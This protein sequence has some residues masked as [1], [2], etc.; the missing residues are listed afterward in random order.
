MS[1]A[2]LQGAERQL[3]QLAAKRRST[4][5]QVDRNK[6][7]IHDGRLAKASMQEAVGTEQ[8]ATAELRRVVDGTRA[9]LAERTAAR[10]ELLRE[11][12]ECE[13]NLEAERESITTAKT[14]RKGLAAAQSALS[15]VHEELMALSSDAAKKAA[16]EAEGCELPTDLVPAPVTVSANAP[17]DPDTLWNKDFADPARDEIRQAYQ[18]ELVLLA[19]QKSLSVRAAGMRES[20]RQLGFAHG[21]TVRTEQLCQV[22]TGDQTSNESRAAEFLAEQGRVVGDQEAE[23][24]KLAQLDAD[25]KELQQRQRA[26]REKLENEEGALN[27]LHE[28]RR[29]DQEQLD[30]ARL[31]HEEL[32]RKHEEA[33]R[34]LEAQRAALDQHPEEAKRRSS[35]AERLALLAEDQ[36]R[37]SLEEL[38]QMQEQLISYQKAHR[39]LQQ[40][41][42]Q[43]LDFLEAEK[44]SFGQLK[45]Q[46]EKQGCELTAL[47]RAYMAAIPE[48]PG[49]DK[50]G[51]PNPRALEVP[52]T[53]APG[54]LPA[55]MSA[56][57]PARVSEAERA[58]LGRTPEPPAQPRY[59]DPTGRGVLN[60]GGRVVLSI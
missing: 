24:G 37:R 44:K 20:L 47:A 42:A 11:L 51:E 46:H 59:L 43:L 49:L 16:L 36:T 50:L 48:L 40:S 10:D 33:A 4:I 39:A 56:V 29:V 21:A 18:S 52:G 25:H 6:A 19:L 53:S 60:A 9:T 26:L 22:A 8:A 5:L 1:K 23:R 38:Q 2:E 34:E 13:R 7:M 57:G 30:A 14:V 41:Y 54:K 35:A 55:W 27:S 31:A 45:A 17:V 58:A 3:E 32:T 28:R 12:A 15:D